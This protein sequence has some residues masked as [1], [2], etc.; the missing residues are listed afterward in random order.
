MTIAAFCLNHMLN[1]AEVSF[2]LCLIMVF[3]CCFFGL[4]S[5]QYSL[6]W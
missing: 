1:H 5:I 4:I 2:P 6:F 3:Y